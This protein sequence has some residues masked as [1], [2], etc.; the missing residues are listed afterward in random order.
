MQAHRM[1]P[2]SEG[3]EVRRDGRQ[4]V[5]VS[6]STVEA[7]ERLSARTLGREGDTESRTCWEETWR[8]HRNSIP[9]QRNNNR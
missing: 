7:G 4:D 5:G 8:V 3:N 1:V 9:C 2:P 6:H